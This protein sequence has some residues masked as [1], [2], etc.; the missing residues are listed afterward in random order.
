MRSFCSPPSFVVVVVCGSYEEVHHVGSAQCRSEQDTGSDMGASP[1]LFI[2]LDKLQGGLQAMVEKAV[3][4]CRV[5][6]TPDADN[7][8]ECCGVHVH[9][10]RFQSMVGSLRNSKPRDDLGRPRVSPQ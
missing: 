1:S 10:G 7:S 4:D 3:S 9:W 6:R 8:S 2:Q 5:Q